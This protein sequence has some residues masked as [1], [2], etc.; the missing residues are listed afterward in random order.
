MNQSTK[1]P[2]ETEVRA[3]RDRAYGDKSSDKNWESCRE[4]WM[5]PDNIEWLKTTLLVRTTKES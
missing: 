2:T 5:E 1:T 4:R 3:M